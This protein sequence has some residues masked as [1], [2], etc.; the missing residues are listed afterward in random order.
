MCGLAQTGW[1]QKFG[2]AVSHVRFATGT[3][4]IRSVRIPAGG[5]NLLLACDIVVGSGGD[6]LAKLSRKASQA[7]VNTYLDMPSDFIRDRD[8]ELP[9]C[10][11]R[12]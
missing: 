7:V 2:A 3:E 1:A 12:D 9:G 11:M 10:A 4:Y 8:Y 5:A 6:A